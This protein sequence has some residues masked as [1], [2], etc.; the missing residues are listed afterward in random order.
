MEE[1]SIQRA[2]A[3]P[4]LVQSKEIDSSYGKFLGEKFTIR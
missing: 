1:E 4:R 3:V 2:L